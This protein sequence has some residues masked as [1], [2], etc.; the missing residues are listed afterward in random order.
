M[1]RLRAAAGAF[2]LTICPAVYARLGR[3]HLPR[4]KKN[5]I[6]ENKER[7]MSTLVLVG[8]RLEAACPGENG[9]SRTVRN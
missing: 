7:A 6:G 1:A 5:E 4:V 9:P 8:Y 3:R 2:G